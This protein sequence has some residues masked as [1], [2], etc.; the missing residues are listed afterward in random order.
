[1]PKKGFFIIVGPWILYL[2]IILLF[3]I[4]FEKINIIV[5]LPIILAIFLSMF[6]FFLGFKNSY[7]KIQYHDFISTK[8]NFIILTI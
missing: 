2:F 3:N 1:M 5:F 8:K 7:N 6:F 4:E